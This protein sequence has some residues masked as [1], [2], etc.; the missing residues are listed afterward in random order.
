MINVGLSQ[1]SR[2][3]GNEVLLYCIVLYS[4]GL[5]LDFIVAVSKVGNSLNFTI[6][7]L[8]ERIGIF[9]LGS[10]GYTFNN[11]SFARRFIDLSCDFRA[12]RL[13]VGEMKSVFLNTAALNGPLHENV[14]YT[15]YAL[16][17]HLG[18]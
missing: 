7:F 9:V 8:N 3:R 16:I 11:C 17:M 5:V 10:S 6:F 14:P 15:R 4:R 12:S 18:L 13:A 2:L 1:I